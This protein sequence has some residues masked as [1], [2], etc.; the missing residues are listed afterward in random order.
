MSSTPLDKVVQN[1]S[2]ALAQIDRNVASRRRS[3]LLGRSVIK[4]GLVTMG[5]I[6]MVPCVYIG[7]SIVERISP[8]EVSTAKREE[9]DDFEHYIS[10]F[11]RAFSD[12][13]AY[14]LAG[15]DD[16]K[17][18]LKGNY[19]KDKVKEAGIPDN[20]YQAI[21]NILQINRIQAGVDAN[22]WEPKYLKDIYVMDP[23]SGIASP[24]KNLEE[25]L[26]RY[27]RCLDVA[28]GNISYATALFFMQ[29][30]EL[31]FCRTSIESRLSFEVRSIVRTTMEGKTSYKDGTLYSV[32][33]TYDTDH[34]Y[35]QTFKDVQDYLTSSG[36][37]SSIVGSFAR[38]MR[39]AK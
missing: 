24:S 16:E 1:E 21:V 13:R 3:R 37:R 7:G 2:D 26:Q 22:S 12:T 10:N 39:V 30:Q 14:M 23:F 17:F 32:G 20:A 11:K 15:H 9:N 6:C 28:K 36:N 33:L 38:D 31:A 5:L 19:L 34:I 35:T 25:G 27:K 4:T 29:P 18:D 8:P